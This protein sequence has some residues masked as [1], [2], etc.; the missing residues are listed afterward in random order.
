MNNIKLWFIEF[1]KKAD[2]L[3]LQI[4]FQLSWYVQ[5]CLEIC[6]LEDATFVC[7]DH[8]SV[9]LLTFS[10]LIMENVLICTIEDYLWITHIEHIYY[11]LIECRIQCK[12]KPII[13]N[14]CSRQHFKSISECDHIELIILLIFH[15]LL[16]TW[17]WVI[18][19][20]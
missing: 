7:N 9:G 1:F 20:E 10:K 8:S 2:L 5:K 13:T 12:H 19:I 15:T 18:N 17:I 4:F 14:E 16:E 11:Q 3:S 6:N